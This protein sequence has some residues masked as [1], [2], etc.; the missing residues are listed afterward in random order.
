ML[1]DGVQFHIQ[2]VPLRLEIGPND[3]T[4]QQ[5]LSVRRDNGVKN[6][7]PLA[8]I[9]ESV[10]SLLN[11]IQKDM[12]ERAKNIYD[13]RVITVTN[14]D[15]LV[16]ALDNKC[17]VA[18]PWCNAEACEDDI[19]ERSGR[20]QVHRPSHSLPSHLLYFLR[21][22]PQDERAPSAGAKSLCIPFDQSRWDPIEPGKTKC[23]ACGKDAKHWTMFGRSYQ[24]MCEEIMGY[25][26]KI[27]GPRQYSVRLYN[28]HS[29]FQSLN[30]A[31]MKKESVSYN[32]QSSRIRLIWTKLERRLCFFSFEQGLS[33]TTAQ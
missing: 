7:I 22:E 9:S 21:S 27:R 29:E 4:M 12:F 30:L 31:A 6:P 16:P 24:T 20:A 15:D 13:S 23:P 5:T 14:W 32:E 3:I 11:T 10:S 18:I 25:L 19:K 2:G 26:L 17:V 8:N 1:I 33:I 28:N